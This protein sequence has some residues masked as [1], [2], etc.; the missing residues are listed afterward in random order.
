MRGLA[1]EPS[2][3][4]ASAEAF[5]AALA[6][7]AAQ[8]FAAGWLRL[9]GVP[10][11]ASDAVTERL[12]AT[13][14]F[15]PPS[16][17][18]TIAPPP[19]AAETIAPPP[20][21]AE[22]IA[23]SAAPPPAPDETIAAPAVS[24]GDETVAAAAWPPPPGPPSPGPPPLAA[25]RPTPP[26]AAPPP[27]SRPNRVPLVLGIAA[28][29]VVGVVVL[30]LLLAGGGGGGGDGEEEVATIGPK[31][32][33]VDGKVSF[34]DTGIDLE[35]D[36]EVLITATGTVFPA[37]GNRSLAASPDGVP[38]HPEIRP[39]NVVPNVDHSG[40]MG[41]V[42]EDGSPFAA[43]STYRFITPSAGRLFLGI[44]DSG[45]ENNDGAFAATVTVTRR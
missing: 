9:S 31:T 15:D 30:V 20:P 2:D 41:K 26:D 34:T 42:G 43:G 35:R 25:P 11:A 24:R 5:G 3:R 21:A 27:P 16:A 13:R 36:D 40:L 6:D 12:R 29:V 4:Y 44:N 33:T 10:L 28:A 38:N 7:A 32:I 18:E 17:A 8:S 19:A 45:L 37:V 22:T 23:P 1:S 14:A 39:A